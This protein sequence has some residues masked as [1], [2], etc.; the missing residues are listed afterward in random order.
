MQHYANID[1]NTRIYGS[2]YHNSPIDIITFIDYYKSVSLDYYTY[3]S[4]LNI[5]IDTTPFNKFKIIF[6]Y[7][8]AYSIS[9]YGTVNI[10]NKLGSTVFHTLILKYLQNYPSKYYN[11]RKIRYEYMIKQLLIAG[12]DFD[13]KN[14]KGKTAL[15]L[16]DERFYQKQDMEELNAYINSILFPRKDA[17]IFIKSV[18]DTTGILYD[19]S[20]VVLSYVSIIRDYEHFNIVYDV[21]KSL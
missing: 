17:I 11:K 4:T 21:Y 12:G 2:M 16:Y 14:D 6:E 1:T 18:S 3:Y 20:N 10:Q 15:D 13:I 8:I 19:V 7:F 5:N 9:V